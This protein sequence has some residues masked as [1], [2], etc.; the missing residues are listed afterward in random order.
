MK[1]ELS[2]GEFIADL[3]KRLDISPSQFEAAKSHYEAVAECLADGGVGDDIY[4]QGSFSYGTVVRP[5]KGGKDADFDI[6]LVSQMAKEKSEADPKALKANVKKCILK[7]PVH[8]D[9]LDEDEGRRC[10]TLNYAPKDG[11]GFHMDILPCVNESSEKIRDIIKSHVDPQYANTAIAITDKDKNTSS[12]S[13]ASGNARGLASWFKEINTPYIYNSSRAQQEWFVENGAYASIDEVPEQLL[14]SPLQRVI[15]LLKRHR[16]CKFCDTPNEEN[17]PISMVITI[18]AAKIAEHKAMYTAT[19]FELLSAFIDEVTCFSALLDDNYEFPAKYLNANILTRN[20]DG[21]YLPNPVNPYENFAERWIEDNH[22]KARAFFQWISWLK[23]D[24]D[25]DGKD[26][27][28]L[29]ESLQA[30]FGLDAVSGVYRALDLNPIK[31]PAIIM[32]SHNPPR[33]YRA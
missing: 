13:W 5:F 6:D 1:K 18:L 14:R 29:F 20:R 32:P 28:T 31:V 4:V 9:L 24:M 7:S 8:A 19:V 27:G 10:W 17:K 3:L 26:S 25:F 33:P 12:Y 16:D 22:A 21:W 30:S 15:Q 11:I 23:T 2:F